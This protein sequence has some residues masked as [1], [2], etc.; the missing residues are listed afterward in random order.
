VVHVVVRVVVDEV[1][2]DEPREDRIGGRGSEDQREAPEEERRQRNADRG[3]HH[4]PQ[5]VVR[6]V[7]VDAVDDEVHAAP[8]VVVR[9]PVEDQPVQPVFGQRPD[10]EA[11]NGEKEELPAH[12][13]A[14]GSQPLHHREHREEDD[15]RDRRM[16]PGEE[17]EEAAI[18]QLRRCGQALCSRLVIHGSSVG[19]GSEESSVR[20]GETSSRTAVF[21]LCEQVAK[22]V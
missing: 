13:A 6:V 10:P 19:N 11:R 8:E 12:E 4:E 20:G 9:L 5:L 16:D 1:P 22:S 21:A 14:V 18:E 2:G 15:R 7:V 17:V 3:W